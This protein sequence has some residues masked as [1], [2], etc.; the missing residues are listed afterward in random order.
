MLNALSV[1]WG[2]FA[3]WGITTVIVRRFQVRA[4]RERQAQCL[5]LALAELQRRRQRDRAA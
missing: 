3:V 4:Q 5:S 2:G 1:L